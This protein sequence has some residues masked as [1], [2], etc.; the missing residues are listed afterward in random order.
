MVNLLNGKELSEQILQE[1]K[2]KI[3]K[4]ENKPKLL[5]ISTGNDKPSQLY[6]ENK[7]K[8]CL[9][10]GAEFQ[11]TRFVSL[12]GEQLLDKI[13]ET[14]LEY[15]N[16]TAILVQLPVFG[17]DKKQT[18]ELF[19]F[20]NKRQDVDCFSSRNVSKIFYGEN[21]FLPCTVQGILD[22]LDKYNIEIEGKHTVVIGRSLIVGKP[23]SLALLNRNAT[24]TICHSK[25]KDLE[26]IT[27]TADILIVAIGKA[28]FIDE[29]HLSPRV[30]V[31]I[32]VGINRDENNKLCGDCNFKE[33]TN[34][35]YWKYG[36][37]NYYITPVPGGVG[38]LTVSSMIKNL[39]KL[40]EKENG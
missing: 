4:M 21:N 24:V 26:Q 25:T 10:V 19:Y 7:R 37:E 17:L 16:T 2:E 39:V 30:K 36:E 28:N 3:D 1:C 34:I 11:E 29:F 13:K 5:V 38:A 6:I 22:L 40:K 14:I 32:D 23:L 9:K 18:N 33:I 8:A 20:M 15:E 35:D 12:Q 27:K 31:I